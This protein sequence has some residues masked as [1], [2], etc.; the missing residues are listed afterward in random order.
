MATAPPRP[1]VLVVDDEPSIRLLC[2]VN[3]EIDGFEVREAGTL[4][5]ARAVIESEPVSVI[6]LDMHIGTERGEELLA[7]LAAREPR[8]PVAAVTGST[9]LVEG[10]HAGADATLTKPFTLAQLAATVAELVGRR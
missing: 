1:V 9:E 7:E 4:A 3:L 5:E 10:R 6:L 2:K 8:I